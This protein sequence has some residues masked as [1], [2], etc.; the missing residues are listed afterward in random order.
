[1]TDFTFTAQARD[2]K[3]T[4]ASRRLRHQGEIPAILIDKKDGTQCLTFIHDKIFNAFENADIFSSIVTVKVGKE[5]HDTMISDVQRH[6]YKRKIMHVD[7][8]K[9]DMKKKLSAWIPLHFIGEEDAPF[10]KEGHF[11]NAIV[12]EIEVTCLPKDLPQSIDVDI[13]AMTTEDSIKLSSIIVPKGVTISELDSEDPE[14][15]VLVAMI[16]AP[17][18]EE[19][20]EDAEE[21]TSG[22]A[23]EKPADDQAKSDGDDA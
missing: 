13:S 2:N 15:D 4:G 9:V 22:E 1:M 19:K 5:S 23:G 12:S 11:L 17:Q 20:A 18:A 8:T 3:G 10:A 14:S 7:F 21:G 6:P 16:S